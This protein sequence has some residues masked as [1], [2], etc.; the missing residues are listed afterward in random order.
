MR[1][2][3][4]G[5]A[6]GPSARPGAVNRHAGWADLDRCMDVAQAK[7]SCRH[8]TASLDGPRYGV[9]GGFSSPMAH[10]PV[11]LERSQEATSDERPLA[12]SRSDS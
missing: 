9:S 7:T 4:L 11:S 2:V 12:C 1:D 5:C 3:R 8:L 6:A 10:H